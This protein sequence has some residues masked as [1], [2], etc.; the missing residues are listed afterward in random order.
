MKNGNK[1][2]IIAASAVCLIILILL[3]TFGSNLLTGNIIARV[4]V[5][6]STFTSD[7]N[8]TAIEGWN[9]LSIPCQT[10]GD[11]LS[12]V[13][14]TINGSYES[15]HKYDTSDS[16]DPWKSYREDLPNWTV[17]DFNSLDH[18]EGFWIRMNRSGEIHY[19]GI[20]VLPNIVQ[21]KQGWNLIGYPTNYTK[22]SSNAFAT[23]SSSLGSV[24]T[25]NAS[26][27][28][29]PWK[30]YSPNLPNAAIDLN[31]TNPG[32]GYWINVTN[33]VVWTILDG[34]Q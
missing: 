26:D 8:V 23:I 5:T 31:F 1:K 20:I 21:L 29:D 25:Y 18:K 22:T 34:E 3:F 11:D 10:L 12:D 30:V 6:G 2:I 16:T 19:T 17:V 32:Q 15:I 9:L 33:D 4:Y 24:H 14:A 28:V 7:C 13:F 27:G